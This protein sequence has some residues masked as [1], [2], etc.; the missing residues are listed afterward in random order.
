M[1]D[2]FE[3]IT[4]FSYGNPATRWV[5]DL[6]NEGLIKT[7]PVKD[8][9]KYILKALGKVI[10][11]GTTYTNNT[12]EVILPERYLDELDNCMMCCG[13]YKHKTPLYKQYGN[14]LYAKAKYAPKFNRNQSLSDYEY[15][16]HWSPKYLE[17]K[18]KSN[19]FVPKSRN[20]YFQYPDKIHFLIDKLSNK[21][22]YDCGQLI[23]NA[24]L[25]E[26]NN[27]EYVL[28]TLDV[29]KIP[30]DLKFYI[31]N[32]WEG[33]SLYTYGNIP[34]DCVCN[35]EYKSFIINRENVPK[36]QLN[37]KHKEIFD[38]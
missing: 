30:P 23:A 21:Q 28:Y 5:V 32:D 38:K 8:T 18:I 13:Y 29:N 24:N 16:Y 9:V 34:Y 3:R 4:E 7:Y 20:D 2:E 33:Y 6:V 19:G 15:L 22:I 17:S 26:M 37:Q 10:K 31:D 27:G 35:L 36:Q 11:T 1:V 12:I 25:N 14:I